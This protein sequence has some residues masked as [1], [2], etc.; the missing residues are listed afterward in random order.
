LGVRGGRSALGTAGQLFRSAA[1]GLP[2]VKR[3]S[4]LTNDDLSRYPVWRYEG[5]SDESAI[6]S[7]VAGFADPDREAYIARTRFV[8]AD[9]SEWWGYCSPTD[10]SGLDYLQPVLITPG[11]PVRFWHDEA[12]PEP[13][14]AR[15][16][17][18]LG[19]PVGR[20]FPARYECVVTVE[21]RVV[22]G[23]L[24]CIA[25]PAEP[26]GALDVAGR[27]GAS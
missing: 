21:G 17:R 14:P 2:F 27:D 8:L 19:R 15:T 16:C 7:P 5:E 10:D 18:L 9:G 23:E 13:E 24:S 12:P 11:G 4:E 20:V 25:V 6:V 22:A 26:G 3:L 1:G